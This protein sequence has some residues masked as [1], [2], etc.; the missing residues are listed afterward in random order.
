MQTMLEKEPGTPWIH[1]LR[2]I[3]L[4]D[5]QANVGFQIFV[6]CHMMKHAV[7]EVTNHFDAAAPL[8]FGD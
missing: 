2:I 4:F 3:E 6:G 8:A 1:R 7:E 5:T